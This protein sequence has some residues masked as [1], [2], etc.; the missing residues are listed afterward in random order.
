M[1]QAHMDIVKN[2]AILICT[3]LNV[4]KCLPLMYENH[5]IPDGILDMLLRAKS[6]QIGL[7]FIG[8]PHPLLYIY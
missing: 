2:N 8:R 3:E 4:I 6:N 5:L 7:L 1:D